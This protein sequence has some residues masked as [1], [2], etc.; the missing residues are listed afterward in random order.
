MT[1]DDSVY[2]DIITPSTN[3]LK[4]I[5]T[6]VVRA[7][8]I[9]EQ[10]ENMADL[11]KQLKG[12]L[13]EITERQLP[14][15]MASAGTAKFETNEGVKVAVRDF[16]RGTL[17]K[18]DYARSKAISY[19]ESMG[20]EAI[21]KDQVKIEFGKSEYARAI[22]FKAQLARDR[23]PF[24][25]AIGVHPQTL[26]AFARERLKNGEPIDMALLGLFSGREA[27]VTLPKK[28]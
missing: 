16:V 23:I 7:V 20:A 18:E 14:D 21:I 22:D 17:P 28:D 11:E 4:D 5:E 8:A 12:E 26:A 27:K 6:K 10:L 9:L 3:E 15:L 1:I 19:I 13:Q 24:D 2:D 25:S